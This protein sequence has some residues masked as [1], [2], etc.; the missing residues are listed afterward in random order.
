MVSFVIWKESI[1]WEERSTSCIRHRVCLVLNPQTW[2]KQCRKWNWINN[3]PFRNFSLF[4]G[5]NNMIRKKFSMSFYWNDFIGS[6]ISDWTE[7]KKTK[8]RMVSSYFFIFGNNV[9]SGP[10][11]EKWK[12]QNLKDCLSTD[13]V[14]SFV[15]LAKKLYWSTKLRKFMVTVK[16]ASRSV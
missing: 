7:R 3:L 16:R 5:C 13:S 4:S 12:I 1:L 15:V 11:Y 14:I 10:K 2:I 9:S 6:K 8:K